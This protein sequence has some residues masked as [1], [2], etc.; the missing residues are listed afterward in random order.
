MATA[1]GSTNITTAPERARSEPASGVARIAVLVMVAVAAIG[2]LFASARLGLLVVAM[3]T[4][5]WLTE[6]SPLVGQPA[7]ADPTVRRLAERLADNLADS[8]L[9]RG[10]H[11]ACLEE[12]A[13]ANKA[14]DVG[15]RTAALAACLAVIDDGLAANPLSGELWLERARLLSASGVFDAPLQ[16]ALRQ[17]YATGPREG[18]I[19]AARLILALRLQPLLPPEF[20]PLILSDLGIVLQSRSLATALV[21]AYVTED[22]LRPT[23]NAALE[24]LP[25]IAAQERFVSWVRSRVNNPV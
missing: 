18:W 1:T 10:R 6:F 13:A 20:T 11:A 21:D 7:D 9:V 4:P 25:D 22:D 17:S 16:T 8:A 23:T 3:P 24:S 5:V 14:A 2:G 15:H 12:V 19:A